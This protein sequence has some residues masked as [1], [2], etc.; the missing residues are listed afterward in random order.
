MT[1]R[2][3][4]FSSSDATI[5]SR[6]GQL[7][8]SVSD[9]PTETYG[10]ADIAVIIAGDGIVTDGET[11]RRIC[12]AGVSL[13][14]VD[15]RGVPVGGTYGWSKH[16]LV[17]KRQH[18]QYQA[19][20]AKRG[21]VHKRLIVS[22][23]LGQANVLL[24]NDPCTSEKLWELARHVKTGDVT[25]RESVAA[26]I[27]WKSFNGGIIRDRFEEDFPNSAL[28]YGYTVLRGHAVRAVIAAGLHPGIGVNHHG[29]SNPFNMADDLIE[30]FRPAVDATVLALCERKSS[31][32]DPETK[33]NLVQASSS[34][35]GTGLHTVA[36]EMELAAQRVGA[37]FEGGDVPKIPLWDGNV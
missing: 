35:M 37:Y 20:S 33:R 8:V 23:I 4:D 3:L 31:M 15:W 2:I 32:N 13:L 24:Q 1:W 5:S 17:G 36:H 11:L 7:R 21:K 26:S 10:L 18:A 14:S 28:N 19:S 12:S 34:I 16:N 22:K 29:P 30:P 27:Y 25:G 9:K 6:H